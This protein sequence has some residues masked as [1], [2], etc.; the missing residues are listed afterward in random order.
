MRF[1]K[2]KL[3]KGFYYLGRFQANFQENNEISNLNATK[4]FFELTSFFFNYSIFSFNNGLY[5]IA[6][7]K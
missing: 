2:K 4:I 1:I 7:I 5:L 6:A 3:K